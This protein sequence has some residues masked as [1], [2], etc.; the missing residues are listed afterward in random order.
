MELL[1]WEFM[2][3]YYSLNGRKVCFLPCRSGSERVKNKNIRPFGKYQHGLLELKLEQLLAVDTLD[4]IV[5][6]T[7][8]EVIIDYCSKLICD[9]LKLD[10]RS[11]S[12]CTSSTS[13]DELI[14]YVPSLF[15]PGDHIMWTHVTSPFI[16]AQCYDHLF[17]AYFENL[18]SHDSLATVSKIQSFLWNDNGPINYDRNIEKWPRTQTLETV[19]ELNS[20][21]FINSYENYVELGDRISEKPYLF[22]LNHFESVDIDW[23]EDFEFAERLSCAT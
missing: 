15:L 6:S 4:M 7:N 8:D 14:E 18:H 13:T 12:L 22:E 23:P 16:G 1:K 11:D 2:K 10:V 9:R 21:A 3:N 19:Y 17:K 5:I 20:G